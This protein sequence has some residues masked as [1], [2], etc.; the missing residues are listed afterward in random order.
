MWR[1]ALSRPAAAASD[2]VGE[3][4]AFRFAGE[5][6][7]ACPSGVLLWPARGALIVSDLH[8][9]KGSWFAARGQP[10]PPYDTSETLDR[11]ARLL[12]HHKPR[13]VIC[14]G[15]SFHDGQAGG[16]WTE[17]ERQ[18]LDACMAGR[19]WLWVLGNHDPCLP[20]SV[21]GTVATE[22]TIAPFTFR[23]QARPQAQAEI[24]G[25]YHPKVRVARRGHRLSYKCALVG[26]DH[27][28][29][30]AFG[31]FTGGL[32]VSDPVY[33]PFKVGGATALALGR[34]RVA[35]VAIA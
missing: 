6:L 11:L 8:L 2:T 32:D 17:T 23:H 27:L 3:P 35:P 26:P 7:L 25:H 13:L 29:L 1:D 21:T 28:I 10:L 9:E 30:P 18:A 4:F 14:L 16:R 34:R 22:R 33:A 19:E 5:R 12:D 31:A 20:A 15:D 24:S